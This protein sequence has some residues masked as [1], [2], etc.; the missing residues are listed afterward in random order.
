MSDNHSARIVY[1]LSQRIIRGDIVS[2]ERLA[3][4]P[5]AEEFSVS[6]TPVRQA[7]AVL[8]R[9]GL[10][11]R[12]ARSYTVRHFSLQEILDAIE[13]RAVLEGL[14]AGE[15]AEK[16]LPQG[17]MR[18]LDAAMNEADD[19]IRAIETDGPTPELTERYFSI[20][21]RFHHAIVAGCGNR[22]VA[23]ALEA[24]GRIPFAS[25]GSI[26]RYSGLD[27]GDQ[28]KRREKVQLLFYSHLQ[29]QDI[30]DAIKSGQAARAEALMREHAH[31]AIRNMHLRDNVPAEL[32]GAMLHYAGPK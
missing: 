9:E 23:A 13:V 8:E 17:I 12:D 29:H 6:R 4:I 31:L 27:K 32:T 2:G 20:N 3:E 25:V 11:I 15:L 5:L 14:A 18:E 10:L 7:L 1:Q 22:T 21:A 19:V 16:R 26:A 30:L 24:A 28:E